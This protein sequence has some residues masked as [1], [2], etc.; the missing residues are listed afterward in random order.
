MIEKRSLFAVL[1]L[2]AFAIAMFVHVASGQ[3]TKK[4]PVITKQPAEKAGP[5]SLHAAL[6]VD[7]TNGFYYGFSFDHPSIEAADQRA[8]DECTK[9]G[10]SCAVVLSWAGTG[11]GAYRTV[12]ANVGTAYGWGV[13]ATKEEADKI[14]T[15]EAR[16]RSKGQ[17]VP[18]FVYA[19]NSATPA[20]LDVFRNDATHTHQITALQF[21]PDGKTLGSGSYDGTARLWSLT[22]GTMLRSFTAVTN[23]D[24]VFFMNNGGLFGFLAGS[25]I[26]IHDAATGDELKKLPA[27]KEGISSASL[28]ADETTFST[29]GYESIARWNAASLARFSYF[30]LGAIRPVVF[31]RDARLAV[32]GLM[33]GGIEIADAATGNRIRSL[34][35]H[36]GQGLD[37]VQALAISP[38]SQFIASSGRD[39]AIQIWSVA[40]GSKIKTL[41]GHGDRIQDLVFSPDGRILASGANDKLVKLWDVNSGALLATLNGHTDWVVALAF[42]ADGRMLASGGN[43]AD[44]TIRIWDV[45]TGK[46]IRVL[47]K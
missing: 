3:T 11:C 38:D 47:S 36:P 30:R 20:A 28:S 21:S 46:E 22:R 19:C 6:A 42:S 15:E 9:R 24:D 2:S 26:A 44:R 37:N 43:T 10:G 1:A 17:P 13:A 40:S 4:K 14:A 39:R 18:N 35:G 29:Q 41:Q 8:L 7:R 45:S 23:V 31:S 5:K 16:R 34:Q 27:P 25:Q 33:G 32:Y 12:A